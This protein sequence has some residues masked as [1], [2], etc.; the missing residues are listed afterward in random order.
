MIKRLA[1]R[2]YSKC[3]S[4]LPDEIVVRLG[5]RQAIGVLPN[6]KCPQTLNEKIAWRKL[7]QRDPRLVLYSDKVSVKNEVAKLI[8]DAHIIKTIWTGEN[9][10]DIPFDDLR[11]PYVV[12]VNHSSGGNVFV[13]SDDDCD[14]SMIVTEMR[15]QLSHPHGLSTREWAYSLIPRRVLV[16]PMLLT[17]DSDV[18]E[19]YKFFVYGG[20][21]EFILV[22]LDRFILHTRALYDRDWREL[23][24]TYQYPAAPRRVPRPQNLSSMIEIA[25]KIGK[26]FD[27]VR[28][29]FYSLDG[30]IYFGETTFY[31]TG[32]LGK[33]T[34]HELDYRFGAPWKIAG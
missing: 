3:Q 24:G 33:F 30:N 21:A 14:R 32:G 10:E 8:G 9:P 27:F 12:K 4:Y 31:P 34:P 15:R 16:E 2:I 22:D 20:R 7:H 19:D 6:I 25:E 23:E 13:R 11:P 28:V 29:D 18:P 17:A 1:R 5:H 26:A